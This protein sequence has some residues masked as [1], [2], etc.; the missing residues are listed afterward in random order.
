MD[1][2]INIIPVKIQECEIP[3]LLLHKI[4]IDF[5][6]VD[7]D[8]ALDKL[9]AS[10]SPKNHLRDLESLKTFL[11]TGEHDKENLVALAKQV[12]NTSW[13]PDGETGRGAQFIAKK[14]D[15]AGYFEEAR[16]V[17]DAALE[18]FPKQLSLLMSRSTMHRRL[19]N[20]SDAD[21][22]C[23]KILQLDDSNVRAL[24]QKFWINN[25]WTYFK[26]TSEAEKKM[27]SQARACLDKLRAI[28]STKTTY[29]YGYLHVLAQGAVLCNDVS[30]ANEASQLLKSKVDE[31]YKCNNQDRVAVLKTL[32]ILEGFYREQ[33]EPDA[34]I[35]LEERR[36]E[37]EDKFKI[38]R[39]A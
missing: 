15:G 26:K 11:A 39:Y 19:K 20:F 2:K 29:I 17:Y 24:I 3:P 13:K 27:I 12:L 5:V 37:L 30:L 28:K 8:I 31:I 16:Q 35:A 14:L 1:K 33:G 25:D 22:D 23:D 21:K 32:K 6:G 7:Y 18:K 36:T 38:Y 34:A 10:L 4:Y 9:A